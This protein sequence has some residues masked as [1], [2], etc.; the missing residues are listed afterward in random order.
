MAARACASTYVE[1]R[2]AGTYSCLRE[3]T[4]SAWCLDTHLF[5]FIFV[6][7]LQRRLSRLS[8]TTAFNQAVVYQNLCIARLRRPAKQARWRAPNPPLSGLESQKL[9]TSRRRPQSV[10][11]IR[12]KG[13]WAFFCVKQQQ[14]LTIAF[15]AH[16]RAATSPQDDDVT[17]PQ[18]EWADLPWPQ[19]CCVSDGASASAATR[20]T[21]KLR[22]PRNK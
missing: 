3:H 7:T 19:R 5:Y 11:P 8:I 20:T 12:R 6:T 16:T 14:A 15:H 18:P 13:P 1:R 17:P 21:C 2:A 9:R 4:L 10:G 22:T